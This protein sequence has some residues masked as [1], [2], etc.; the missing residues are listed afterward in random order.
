[1][2]MTYNMFGIG[3]VDSAPNEGGAKLAYEEGWY[4]P[5]AAVDGGT[6]WISKQY[7]QNQYK[8]DTLYKMK[9]NPQMVNGANWKQYE[10]DVD[11]ASK[12]VDLIYN[13]YKEIGFTDSMKFDYPVYKLVSKAHYKMWAFKMKTL[14]HNYLEETF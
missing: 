13:I 10:T 9:W 3:A 7:I 12:Q 2:K 4:T 14:C 8:Q 5:K 6:E 1:I 11:W